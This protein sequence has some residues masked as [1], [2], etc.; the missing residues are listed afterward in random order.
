MPAHAPPAKLAK[1]SDRETRLRDR[2][3]DGFLDAWNLRRQGPSRPDLYGPRSSRV[4]QEMD[5]SKR[6]HY[7]QVIGGFVDRFRPDRRDFRRR[8]HE[9]CLRGRTLDDTLMAQ[10]LSEMGVEALKRHIGVAMA[11]DADGQ[12]SLLDLY[13]MQFLPPPSSVADT[14]PD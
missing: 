6:L 1:P 8:L 12:R 5:S 11:D 9:R 3:I 10:T 2:Q 4:E 14:D 13:E 7:R